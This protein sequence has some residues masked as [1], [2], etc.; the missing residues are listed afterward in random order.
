MLSWYQ[1]LGVAVAPLGRDVVRVELHGP[2]ALVA[3]APAVE[4]DLTVSVSGAAAA[5][6]TC[7]AIGE[8]AIPAPMVCV[9]VAN[10]R[11]GWTAQRSSPSKPPDRYCTS[12]TAPPVP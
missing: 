1:K 4:L 5:C 12:A 9:D 11:V 7:T 8:D 6:E 3:N 10:A 2:E